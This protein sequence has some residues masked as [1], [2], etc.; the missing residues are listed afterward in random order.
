MAN[1]TSC[2]GDPIRK[3]VAGIK[4]ELNTPIDGFACVWNDMDDQECYIIQTDS[5]TTVQ[6][7]NPEEQF[8]GFEKQDEAIKFF[9]SI[10]DKLESGAIV[11]I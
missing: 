8:K 3:G 7:W 6:W 9:L 11:S 2:Y 1:L 4:R 10:L 5:N